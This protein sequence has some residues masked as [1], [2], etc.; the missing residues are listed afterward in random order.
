MITPRLA[1][2]IEETLGHR[3]H[4]ANLRDALESAGASAEV[5]GIAPGPIS[6]RL[7]WALSSSAKAWRATRA[8]GRFDATFFHTQTVSLLAP[9]ATRGAP[10]IVSV[11]ATPV[12]MDAM[13]QWYAHRA[14]GSV[15]ERL[16]RAWYRSIFRRAGGVVAWSQWALDSVVADY[17]VTPE[18]SLVAHPGAGPAFFEVGRRR[19]PNRERP[20]I[21]FVGGQF[22]RKG[23]QHL[24][25]AFASL[26]DRADLL[27]VT[28][29]DV[30]SMPGVEVRRGIRPHTPELHQA[31][32]DADIFCL[33]TLGDCTPVAIGEAMASGLPV[34][35][36]T[37]GSNHEWVQPQ[38]GLLAP[39]GDTEALRN[40]L[41][42]LV[43]DPEARRGLSEGAFR[44][45]SQ[46]MDSRANALRILDLL[47]EVA[48]PRSL[49][50]AR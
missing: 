49:V 46:H 43:D 27:L 16:K 34:V 15:A 37:V 14:G 32:A 48:V 41:A 31:F 45:A 24:L 47:H 29:D 44:F 7:P 42:R 4:G 12:Q 36:T 1:L 5:L 35:T 26:R 9:L 20:R 28:E 22:E 50:T 23:G 17:G 2:V 18:R 10:F 40:A 39:P 11:D 25:E 38:A 3:A 19:H 8:A 13:G 6:S 30:P 21:L 33:P